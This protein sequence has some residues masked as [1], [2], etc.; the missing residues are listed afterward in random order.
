MTSL[1][2]GIPSKKE[3]SV[4]CSSKSS[5]LYLPYSTIPPKTRIRVPS[6]TKPKAAQP[7]GISPLTGGTN[8]WFVAGKK[9][10]AKSIKGTVYQYRD[11]EFYLKNLHMADPYAP[12][13]LYITSH[14]YF[15][16][17]V[18][19]MVLS[20]YLYVMLSSCKDVRMPTLIIQE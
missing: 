16:R 9:I 8:H 18:V 7:G 12:L 20:K 19:G 5:L 11:S 17:Q 15:I 13:T 10:R 4:T 14:V 2:L 1:C 3:R 6:T